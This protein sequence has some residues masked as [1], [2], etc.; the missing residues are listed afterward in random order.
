LLCATKDEEVV[1]YALA[2]TSSPTLVAEYQTMLP[3]NMHLVQ[4]LRILRRIA[5]ELG[6]ALLAASLPLA[7][8]W[9]ALITFG[10]VQAYWRRVPIGFGLLLETILRK[11]DVAIAAPEMA[12]A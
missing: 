9:G 12:E 7:V 4:P 2:L 1:E 5:K 10:S 11:R 8:W 3:P 6:R